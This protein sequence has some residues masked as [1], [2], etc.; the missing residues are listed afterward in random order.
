MYRSVDYRREVEGLDGQEK[1]WR[2]AFSR[3]YGRVI[4]SASFRR[5][6]GKTQVFPSRESDFFRNRLTHSLEVAQIAQGIAERLNHTHSEDL[7]G[8]IDGRL[9]ATAG[10]IHD[11][12]HPPFG[13]N[14]EKA[15]DK[16]MRHYGGFEGNAQTLRILTRLE[17]KK[18]YP[19]PLDGDSRAGYNLCHRTVASALKY[20]RLIPAERA[21]DDELVKGYYSSEQTIVAR[22]KDSILDGYQLRHD[23]VFRTIECSIM[24]LADDIAYSVYDLE[25]CLKVGILTPAEILV[26]EDGLLR[27]VAEAVSK[28]LGYDVKASDVL[29]VFLDIFAALLNDDRIEQEKDERERERV[30]RSFTEVYISSKSLAEDGYSR[31][32]LSSEL[33]HNFITGVELTVHNE[34]MALSSVRLPKELALRKEVLKQYTFAAAIY[35]PRVKLGEYRGSDLVTEIF[36][37]LMSKKG[38]LLMPPDVRRIVIEAS[39][40]NEKARAVCDFVAGMTDR[41]AMEFWAR[42]NSDSAESMFKPI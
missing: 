38:D 12:G 27:V 13:H 14:G 41:Y 39:S 10:L 4:H 9:C 7:G 34:C 6:Q 18:R 26:S 42:L 19:Q 35:S 8:G 28:Q 20:D 1:E 29:Y 25:D 40:E 16:A 33:V 36:D 37:A 17:K 30:L 3:D 15:L 24:D 5:L 23:E 32:R 31:T 21:D 11:I 22:V 2:D